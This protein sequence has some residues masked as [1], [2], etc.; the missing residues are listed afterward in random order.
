MTLLCFQMWEQ[1]FVVM[2]LMLWYLN[3]VA[4]IH[5]FDGKNLQSQHLMQDMTKRNAIRTKSR[6]RFLDAILTENK[7]NVENARVATRRLLDGILR[8]NKRNLNQI[9]AQAVNYHYLDGMFGENRRHLIIAQR[10]N[11]RFLDGNLGSKKTNVSQSTLRAVSIALSLHNLLERSRQKKREQAASNIRNIIANIKQQNDEG[12][13]NRELEQVNQQAE[14]ANIDQGASMKTTIRNLQ[15]NTN[16]I[17]R[18]TLSSLFRD[19]FAT[20]KRHVD[21]VAAKRKELTAYG[22]RD[23]LNGQQMSDEVNGHDVKDELNG[24]S[25]TLLGQSAEQTM[26]ELRRVTTA[27]HIN[28]QHAARRAIANLINNINGK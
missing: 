21:E 1:T 6:H 4:A 27:R 7:R 11:H 16:N 26:M 20:V 14:R 5:R 15:K 3:D 24:R 10:S 8:Q 25:N 9:I 17:K 13:L 28:A 19:T 23:K 12:T 2:T 22:V 18:N